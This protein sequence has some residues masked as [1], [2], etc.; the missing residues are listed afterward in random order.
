[1]HA[2]CMGKTHNY[3]LKMDVDRDPNLLVGSRGDSVFDSISRCITFDRKNFRKD[4]EIFERALEYTM[5]K[6]HIGM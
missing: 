5:N 1:M 3:I 6:T 4:I 2:L